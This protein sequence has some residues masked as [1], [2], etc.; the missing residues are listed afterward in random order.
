MSR[1]TF[2]SNKELVGH[3]NLLHHLRH[4]LLEKSSSDQCFCNRFIL[5]LKINQVNT[6]QHRLYGV[7]RKGT[8]TVYDNLPLQQ[9]TSS[10]VLDD[11]NYIFIL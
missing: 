2:N 1:S 11:F 5:E 4:R 8:I 6:F 7:Y 3:F 9:H 10:K